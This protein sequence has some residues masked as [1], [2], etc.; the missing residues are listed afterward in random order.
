MYVCADDW[1]ISLNRSRTGGNQTVNCGGISRNVAVRGF[2][3]LC[4][5]ISTAQSSLWAPDPLPPNNQ[6]RDTQAL[7]P[8]RSLPL[9]CSPCSPSIVIDIVNTNLHHFRRL[10]RIRSA[11]PQSNLA[12]RPMS[13]SAASFYAVTAQQVQPFVKNIDDIPILELKGSIR[14]SVFTRNDKRYAGSRRFCFRGLTQNLRSPAALP[15]M[16]ASSMEHCRR[17]P[18]Y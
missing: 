2:E 10:K 11:R 13:T 16:L 4:R 3:I 9:S 5:A 8:F 18:A 7:R 1:S 15:T 6:R 14:G 17:P 12:W